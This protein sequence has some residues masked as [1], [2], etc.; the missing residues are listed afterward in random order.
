MIKP[1][2]EDISLNDHR[3]RMAT[4]HED[5]GLRNLRY[6]CLVFVYGS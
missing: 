1:R 4:Y 5:E 3:L 2:W 6:E